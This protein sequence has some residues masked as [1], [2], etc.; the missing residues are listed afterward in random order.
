MLR[1]IFSVFVLTVLTFASMYG[2]KKG[3]YGVFLGTSYY[4]G[5]LNPSKHIANVANESFGLVYR[6]NFNSRYSLRFNGT[7]GKLTGRDEL[8]DI[9]LNNYRNLKMET[10]VIEVGMMLEFNFFSFGFTTE[11]SRF[12]PYLQVGLAGYRAKPTVESLETSSG[13]ALSE[14]Y[15]GETVAS[16]AF[17]F[18]LGVRWM[19]GSGIN[20]SAEWTVHK[21]FND[22]LDGVNNQY[23]SGNVR[24][25]PGQYSHFIGFQKGNRTN[26]D[27][28][29]FVGIVLSYRV[30]PRKNDCWG[31]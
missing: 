15:T 16:V 12:T 24:D 8:F 6:N 2:Q 9:G 28:Y 5:E 29:S 31:H 3:E 21:T 30:G 10:S 27:W 20:L 23:E 13:T 25:E 22:K 11:D 26:N 7:Y 1:K 19:I 14:S 18:G 4:N 17:P